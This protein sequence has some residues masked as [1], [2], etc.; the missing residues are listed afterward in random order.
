MLKLGKVNILHNN[1]FVKVIVRRKEVL[2]FSSANLRTVGTNV[3]IPETCYSTNLQS[4][5]KSKYVAP[6]FFEGYIC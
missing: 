6:R 4:F 3:S 1:E 5:Q 2:Y